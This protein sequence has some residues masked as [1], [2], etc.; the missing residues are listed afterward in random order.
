SNPVLGDCNGVGRGG[1]HHQAPE[2]SR[3][4]QIHVV[5]ADANSSHNLQPLARGLEHLAGD[6]GP[7]THDQRV[8]ERD[9]GAEEQSVNC[10]RRLIPGSLSFSETRTVGLA[11]RVE[12][13]VM[14]EVAATVV[15]LYV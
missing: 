7:A 13:A 6:L 15:L 2:L 11:S 12:P 3:H 5:D 14:L 8:A 9:L 10:F 1:V 4:S